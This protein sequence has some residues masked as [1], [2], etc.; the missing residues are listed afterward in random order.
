LI[1][2]VIG[3]GGGSTDAVFKAILWA[4]ESGAQVIS[5]SLGMDFPAYREHLALTFPDKLATSMAL[6][7]YRS[8]VQLFDRL[9]HLICGRNDFVSGAV[10]VAA[11]GNESKRDVNP[12]Y[13]VVVAP[14]AAAEMFISVAALGE[15][16]NGVSNPYAVAPFSNTGVRIAAPGV[17]IWSAKLGG[18]LTL[19]S[20]T[21]MAT[22]H[23]AGVAALWGQR[24]IQQ[25]R[26]FRAGWVIDQL[27]RSAVELTGLDPDDVGL[28]LAQAP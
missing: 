27:E 28:G 24:L 1:G 12:D 2:K 15:T 22:P 3:D 7:G 26:P 23:V 10:V 6:A 11:A 20:G 13:R 9:S 5:M 16:G 19:K 4:F 14:P 25:G 21:S 8:N 18:G 17:K